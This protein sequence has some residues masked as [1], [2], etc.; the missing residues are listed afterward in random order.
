MIL[1]L[2]GV[3]PLNIHLILIDPRK[4][5][6]PSPITRSERSQRSANLAE[7]LFYLLYCGHGSRYHGAIDREMF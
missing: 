1:I 4:G 5:V 6:S 2:K 3:S 7:I